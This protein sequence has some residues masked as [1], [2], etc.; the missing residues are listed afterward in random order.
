MP[1]EETNTNTL[2]LG[3]YPNGPYIKIGPDVPSVL[4]S[5]N[6]D[7]TWQ[8]AMLWYYNDGVSFYFQA[9]VF[10]SNFGLSEWITGEYITPGP[11]QLQ[12]FIDGP[13]G[14]PN[15]IH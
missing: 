2:I 12:Q 1:W 15:S 8:F 10:N 5:F 11:V 13:G 7:Y 4:T 14:S 9:L 6:S 3:N